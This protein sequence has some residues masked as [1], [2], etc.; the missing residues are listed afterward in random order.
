MKVLLYFQDYDKIG[1]SG[2][3]R[4]Q[5]HQ[6]IALKKMGIDV[7]YDPKD[8]F[9]IAHI[10]TIWGKSERLLKR[11]KKKGI[12]VIVHGHSTHEDF[13][14]SFACWKIIEPFFD[15][16]LDKMYR[17][18]DII[19]TPTEY[20]KKCIDSYGLGTKTVVVSNGIDVQEYQENIEA[21]IAFRK[22][23]SIGKDEKFVMGVGFPFMRKGIDTFFEVAK[24]Y[25]NTKFIW[26]GHLNWILQSSSIHRLLSHKPANVIMPG[27][28]KGDLI[29]ASYQL[30]SCM[31]FPSREE[32]EGIVTLEAL[33][34]ETPLL[35]R[36]IAVYDSWLVDG[37]NCHKAK[38]TEEFISKLGRLLNEG[39]DP[40][41]LKSGYETAKERSLD[42][43]G[44][45]LKHVYHSLLKQKNAG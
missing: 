11:C 41:I 30:S 25:P 45:E 9:D 20:S 17:A 39:E 2:I 36:D 28:I 34:S 23:F 44:E 18:A 29:K 13:R 26:F 7:T 43:V 5:R 6:T 38:T 27:Y 37:V 33:A 14:D 21:Q 16:Q 22:L 19:I 12:P 24:A 1:N 4:A 42:A 32:T 31:L 3:G 8:S 35:V 40:S 15:H 10:N